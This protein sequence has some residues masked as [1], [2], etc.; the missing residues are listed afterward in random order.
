[1]R[2]YTFRSVLLFSALTTV[3]AQASVTLIGYGALDQAA[4]LSGRTD[5]LENGNPQNILGGIGSGLT[6]AGGNTFLAVPDRGPNAASYN[7]AIDNTTSYI[8]RF[9]T[10]N[11]TL[12]A[13]NGG[14][15]PFVVTPVLSK[16]TL[17][18][19]AQSL[20]YGS[21]AGLGT[22]SSGAPL[23]A[24]N[25]VNTAPGI[26]YFTGRSDNYGSGGSGVQ[27]NARFD[28]ESI[29]VSPDGKSVFISDEYGPYVKQFDR[30]TGQLI[31]SFKLPDKFYVANQAPIGANEEKPPKVPG[32]T[33]GR[34]DNKG[35][36]GL[37]IT[38]DGKTLVGIM[39]A[40]LLQDAKGMLRIVT[41]D[42]ASGKT[43]HEYAYQL[44][45]GSGVSE[46]TAIND[47]QFLVDER[48]GAGVGGD[49]GTGKKDL[50]V[51]DLN[52]AKDVS[53]IAKLSSNNGD[54]AAVGKTQFADVA[55]LL[56]AAGIAVPS[57]I[58][59]VTF[60]ADVTYNGQTEHTLWV[61]NDNDFTP[62][63]SGKNQFFVFGFTDVDLPGFEQV[64]AVPEPSTWA[65]FLV[66]FAGI[67][68]VAYRRKKYIF[69]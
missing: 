52:N 65:M 53:G 46:I 69:A 67:S 7:A 4:D 31:N 59:G 23:P 24:G 56:T 60:G 39:Q 32:N 30:A 57:K 44:T 21:G 62:D 17:L 66:G 47:H 64:A 25:A 49:P 42:I 43:T 3:P 41:I 29:R 34:T 19:S 8:S 9:Q 10:L 45:S 14:A 15:L 16:T 61:A 37:A 51:I 35:M 20:N 40:N 58:E 1:M 33:T 22:T 50:Y 68:L 2:K 36:E 13:S 18:Y 5:I 48:D 38:P 54:H 26:N 11:M 28:P 55:G 27:N 12:T 6:Y 63:V